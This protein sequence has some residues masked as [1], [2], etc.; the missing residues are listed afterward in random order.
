MQALRKIAVLSSS[1]LLL[2]IFLALPVSPVHAAT[3][4]VCLIPTGSTTCPSSP[5]SLFG[6]VGSQLRVS[7]FIQGS[8]ALNGFDVTVLADRTILVPA[9][10]DITGTV[11]GSNPTIVSKCIGGVLVIGPN[12]TATSTPNTIELAAVTQPGV[13]IPPPVTG[14]LFTAVYNVAAA[15]SG[16]PVGF[17]TG[18]T[19]TSVS[20]TCVTIA[21]G[22][23]TPDPES[24]QTATFSTTAPPPDFDMSAGPSSLSLVQGMSGTSNI[25][26]TS[27]NNFQGTVTL[28]DSTSSPAIAAT[29]GT[30]SVT[31]TPGASAGIALTV[32]TTTSTPPGTYTVTVSGTSGTLSHAVAVTIV[33]SAPAPPPDFSISSSGTSFALGRGSAAFPTITLTSLNGFSGTVNIQVSVTPA[34]THPVIASVNP[35]SVNLASGGTA[36]TPLTINAAHNTVPG[37]YT[38]TVT[39]TSGSLSHSVTISVT[40]HK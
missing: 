36:S 16:I 15:T 38:I 14:L 4:T 11:L 20:G 26:V 18:C 25:V 8:D 3:G 29:L 6:S 24:V 30:N 17:Q 31:L 35:T 33:V 39:G 32:A 21:N 5:A 28:T 23:P 27:L 2:G 34:T 7:V 9:D 12:C 19:T 22:S 1:L 40:V 13:L 37:S 10:A